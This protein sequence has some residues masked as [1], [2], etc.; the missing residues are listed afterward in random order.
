MHTRVDWAA[1]DLILLDMDGTVLDLAFDNHFWGE[2]VPR[3]YARARGLT[4]AQAL[5]ELQPHFDG[6]RG[7]LPWYSLEHWSRLTGVD[8]IALK[9]EHRHGIAPRAGA[10]DFLSAARAAGRRLWLATNADPHALDIKLLHTGL[11]DAF[12]R[13]IT[14][15]DFDAPKE[16]RE[17]WQRLVERHPFD[18]ARA[19][20]VD[21]SGP[22]LAAA[23]AF[24]IGQVVA[25]RHPDSRRP[26][27][28]VPG[29]PAVDRLVDLLPVPP[30]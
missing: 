12:E 9:R 27:R 3:A 17:F 6:L 22:V 23:R 11:E 8:L 7:T 26:A 1:V 19:L 13:L 30:L 15:H 10:Q 18:P 24:G 16:E 20:F 28:D 21:D 5:A 4:E 25:I 2:A 29:F 14:A